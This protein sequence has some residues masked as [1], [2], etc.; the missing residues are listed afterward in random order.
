MAWMVAPSWHMCLGASRYSHATCMHTCSA[1]YHISLVWML[2]AYFIVMIPLLFC[3]MPT[4]RHAFNVN[5]MNCRSGFFQAQMHALGGSDPSGRRSGLTSQ[6]ITKI[7]LRVYSHNDWPSFINLTTCLI[8]LGNFKLGLSLRTLNGQL[9]FHV[10]GLDTWLQVK[11]SYS[12]CMHRASSLS[13]M[14]AA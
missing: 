5:L 4:C 3:L 13:P 8:R 2:Y 11:D 14:G 12:S 6:Q 9:A 1:L 10:K 7:R